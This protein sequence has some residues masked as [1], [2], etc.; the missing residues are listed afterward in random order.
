MTAADLPDTRQKLLAEIERVGARRRE[1]ADAFE[2]ALDRDKAAAEASRAELQALNEQLTG[3]GVLGRAVLQLKAGAA[4]HRLR[5]AMQ[6]H[7]ANAGQAPVI[8]AALAT[9]DARLAALRDRLLALPAGQEE[10]AT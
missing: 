4:M 6:K 1:I 9:R 2:A 7:Q 5:S 10:Q 3:A 8:L